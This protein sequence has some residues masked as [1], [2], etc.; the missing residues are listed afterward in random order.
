MPQFLPS[1]S[2]MKTES[3]IDIITVLPFAQG[4]V[5]PPLA[6]DSYLLSTPGWLKPLRAQPP[7][8]RDLSMLPP[9]QRDAGVLSASLVG[10]DQAPR[11]NAL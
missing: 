1:L 2:G 9:H 8:E 4:H 3:I 7:S 5:H 10:G 11:N 6:A